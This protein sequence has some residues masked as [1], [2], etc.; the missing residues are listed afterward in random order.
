ME[1]SLTRLAACARDVAERAEAAQD[2]RQG[3]MDRLHKAMMEYRAAA[4]GYVAH[5]SVGDFVRADACRYDGETRRA[6]E[7]IADLI[8][9]L[10]ELR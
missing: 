9:H 2:G 4:V 10:N 7:R 5:P 3:S 1:K 8:D 6:V